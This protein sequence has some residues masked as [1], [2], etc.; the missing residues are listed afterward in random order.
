MKMKKNYLRTLACA[1]LIPAFSQAQVI[2]FQKIYAAT[3]HES[4]KD[5]LQTPDGGYIIAAST[6][7]SIPNDLD[8]MIVRTNNLGDTLWRKKF[9][10]NMPDVPN[11]ILRAN[12][13]NYFVIGFTQSTTSGD[14]D[15]FLLKIDQL[16]GAAIFTKTYGGYGYE[17]GKEIIATSDG[18]YMI[19]GAS[20]S[21]SFSDNNAELIKIDPSGN[22]IWTKYYGGPDYESARSVKQCADGGFIVAGKRLNSAGMSSVYLIRTNSGGDTLWTKLYSGGSASWE[23]KSILVNADGSYTLTADDSTV[24]NDSDVRIMH[25]DPAGNMDWT[26]LY[27]GT[28]KDISKMIQPTTDGGYIVSALSRSFGW[29][30]PDYWILKLNSAGD[31]LW[32]RHYGGTDHE[33]CYAV[34]QTADGGYIAVGHS[35]SNPSRVEEIMLIKM[36]ASGTL[37]PLGVSE[38][39]FADGFYM[40]PNPSGGNVELYLPDLKG[41]AQ[42]RIV[43]MLGQV[44]YDKKVDTND[45]LA[46]DLGNNPPGVYHVSLISGEQRITRKLVIN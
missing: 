43:N 25:F 1:L 15:H 16:T 2:T 39:K 4:G 29:I 37:D 6:E 34:R 19:V 31:T 27:G 12:D 26:K 40:Y 35:R 44:V 23:S 11:G 14:V 7:T 33:H 45:R 36:N 13:G 9:G 22:V 17:E 30:D 38:E 18:N 41:T 42:C 10:G 28:D 24:T 3:I 5:V 8:V 20:N 21:I 46:L 32:T